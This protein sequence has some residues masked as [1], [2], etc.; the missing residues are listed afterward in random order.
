[1]N[2]AVLAKLL[3]L[4]AL[5]GPASVLVTCRLAR[6]VTAEMR[7]ACNRLG[8]TALVTTGLVAT[9]LS[10]Q[11][12]AGIVE[13]RVTGDSPFL[14]LPMIGRPLAMVSGRLHLLILGVAAIAVIW[15]VLT[16]IRDR[17]FGKGS[18]P[19]RLVVV[20]W[21]VW[22]ATNATL[23][24]LRAVHPPGTAVVAYAATAMSVGAV[25]LCVRRVDYDLAIRMVAT[26]AG[27]GVLL[28]YIALAL[29]PPWSWTDAWTGGFRVGFRLQG[30]FP[31]PNVAGHFFAVTIILICCLTRIRRSVRMLLAAPVLA[32]I[33]LTGSRGALILLLVGLLGTR[34]ARPM[35]AR[36][37][38]LV[39]GA[40]V[41][42]VI[43]PLKYMD[44]QGGLLAGR[45]G[46]WR[47]TLAMAESSPLVGNGSLSQ[48]TE[49]G[50]YAIYAHSQLLQTLAE[51]GA[52]GLILLVTTLAATLRHVVRHGSPL[53]AGI[54]VGL[55]SLFPFENP[56]RLFEPTFAVML[57][58]WLVLLLSPRPAAA[59]GSQAS[60]APEGRALRS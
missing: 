11:L 57:V 16:A 20:L 35:R 30:I 36:Y 44:A 42:S 60:L 40:A 1:M 41:L 38:F 39:A 31:Q 50:G 53:E 21:I 19:G 51:C 34:L 2:T 59:A 46:T 18:P 37:A 22:V 45:P 13:R 12:L 54:F 29:S 15:A 5:V 7:Q 25:L 28:T 17:E 4:L 56:V 32:L 8:S 24:C 23:T 6:T 43:L 14:G 9:M 47:A 55:I 10:L 49:S 48:Q 26:V 52:L 27:I 58:L 33:F 3:P